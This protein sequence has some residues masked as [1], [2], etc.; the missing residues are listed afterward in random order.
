MIHFVVHEEGDSVGTI[1][2]EGV[3]SGAT[4]SGWIMEQDR[5]TEIKTRSDIPIG[6]KIALQ[7]LEV[8]ATVIKYGV[9]IGKVVAPIAAGEHLH[10]QNV[11]TKRW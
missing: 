1:V 6:H 3:K 7:Q 11:K 10:V 9:D 8:G 4:L 5:M 2:V